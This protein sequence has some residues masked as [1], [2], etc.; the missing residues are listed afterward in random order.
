MISSPS[1]SHYPLAPGICSQA[2][3][4]AWEKLLT[5]TLRKGGM[6]TRQLTSCFA[7]AMTGNPDGEEPQAQWF[8]M[9]VWH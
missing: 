1:S 7:E 4:A 3:T 9:I 6:Q 8:V 5:C 2:P